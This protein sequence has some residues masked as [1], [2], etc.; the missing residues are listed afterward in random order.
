LVG[1]AEI[2]AWEIA[3]GCSKYWAAWFL[4]ASA[5]GW[6]VVVSPKRVYRAF[7]RGRHSRTLYRTGWTDD[8]LELTVGELRERLEVDREPKATWTDR[9]AFAGW[10][11][12]AASPG[13]IAVALIAGF[14]R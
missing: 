2:G 10:V 14:V 4:N 8:L 5:F 11:A 1:E 13:A 9:A 6:G 12:L 3:G 7:I